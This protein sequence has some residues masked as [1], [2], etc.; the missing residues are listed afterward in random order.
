[1]L[2]AIIHVLLLSRSFAVASVAGEHGDWQKEY[3]IEDAI[4]P[5]PFAIE[6]DLLLE[7]LLYTV[8]SRYIVK[9]LSEKEHTVYRDLKSCGEG[10]RCSV[11]T[12]STLFSNAPAIPETDGTAFAYIILD[13]RE[14]AVV[15]EEARATRGM[16]KMPNI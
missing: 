1:M 16:H 13:S 6:G 15:D 14:L 12:H 4:A 11:I 10:L 9:R 2:F 5:I 7:R 3:R 8:Y